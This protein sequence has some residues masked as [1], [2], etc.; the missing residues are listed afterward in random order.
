MLQVT[1]PRGSGEGGDWNPSLSELEPELLCGKPEA[2][3]GSSCVI[4]GRPRPRSPPSPV[5]GVYTA[6]PASWGPM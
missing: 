1:L 6:Q 5:H 3:V 4:W 2:C